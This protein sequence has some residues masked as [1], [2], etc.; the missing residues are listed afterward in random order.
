MLLNYSLFERVYLL[1]AM[2]WIDDGT[3]DQWH[4]WM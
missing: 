4:T 3:C 2:K 1:H